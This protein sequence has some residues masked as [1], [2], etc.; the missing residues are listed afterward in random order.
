MRRFF[1]E[2]SA[3]ISDI[4]EVS[5]DFSHIINVLRYSE[6]DIIELFD[7][8][9]FQYTAAIL[10][11]YKQDNIIEVSI[12]DKTA[13][14]SESNIDITVAQAFLKDGSV[15]MG[16]IIRQ[17][18]EL[19]IK[20]WIP[21]IAERS[22]PKIDAKSIEKKKKR[23]EKLALEAVKQTGRRFI[24]EI[25]D[26]LSFKEMIEKGSLYDIKIIFYEEE[27]KPLITFDSNI[28]SVFII[29]GPEGGFSEKEVILAKN[30]GFISAGLGPRILK[31][32]T[33]AIAATSIIQF[34]YGD[35]GSFF[36]R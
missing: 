3:D 11:I 22:V 34:I 15:S 33:A 27:K 32:P 14:L 7:A 30:A 20:K 18:T 25:S 2:K 17:L 19:G 28:K 5:K 35:M 9:G 16:T 36:K 26:V 6:E 24:P 31:A 21:F 12:K 1:I 29:I 23:W 8:E 10:H 13:P 4:V